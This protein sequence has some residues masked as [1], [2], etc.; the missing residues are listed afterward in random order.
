MDFH[1]VTSLANG[2]VKTH[3]CRDAMARIT[4]KLLLCLLHVNHKEAGY[5]S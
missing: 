5:S 2:P 3:N 1:E 4:A